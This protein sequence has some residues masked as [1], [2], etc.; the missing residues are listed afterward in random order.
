MEAAV[1]SGRAPEARRHVERLEAVAAANGS[2]WARGTALRCRALLGTDDAASARYAESAQ[3]LDDAGAVVDAARS[4]LLQGELL[5][6]RRRRA[7]ARAL[8][9][10]AQDVFEAA[11]ATAFARRARAELT[12]AGAE[13]GDARAVRR[14]PLTPREETV[15]RLAADGGTNA[16]IG[17]TLFISA[18]TV[19]YHLR[20]VFHKLGV[21][22]RRQLRAR[23]AATAR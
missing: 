5:R 18:H 17:A 19:D 14:S 2:P 4:R 12:A 9:R 21:S 8:L 15:A 1:R 20:K 6:R 16:E 13:P 10:S 7:E 22:S 3:A 23:L 11:G